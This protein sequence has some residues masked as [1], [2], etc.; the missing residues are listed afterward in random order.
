MQAPNQIAYWLGRTP[1]LFLHQLWKCK[2]D[3]G[4][5]AL[6]MSK[7]VLRPG[8]GKEVLAA[9]AKIK[10]LYA[11]ILYFKQLLW[12]AAAKIID[13]KLTTTIK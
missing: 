2:Y 11:G 5:S 13:L 7:A 10:N 9:S 1:F 3:Q 12:K 8:S 4:R 6:L